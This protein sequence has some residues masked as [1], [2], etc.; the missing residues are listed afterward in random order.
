[1]T[2]Q[3]NKVSNLKEEQENQARR[4]T[5]ENSERISLL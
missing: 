1:M 3:A 2:E 4:I 5:E